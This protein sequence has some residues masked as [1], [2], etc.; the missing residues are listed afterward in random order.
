MMSKRMS[1]QE[2]LA[3]EVP[4]AETIGELSDYIESL[5]QQEHDYGT[6]VY[7]MSMAATAAF[8]Y[9]AHRLGVTGF[10]ASCADL[11]VLRRTRRITGPFML[12]D[13]NRMLYPQYSIERDVRE[14]MNEWLP[15]AA[16][17]AR[18]LLAARSEHTSPNVLK[19]WKALAATV[20][21]KEE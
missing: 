20:P 19:H 13:S 1:E 14:A 9:V 12:V 7:A 10:Q 6:C 16:G 11:D 17:E 3:A 8:N 18:K 5:V 2:M 4:S 21:A 15:W